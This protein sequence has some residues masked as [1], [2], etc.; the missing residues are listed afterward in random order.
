MLLM[1]SAPRQI[2]RALSI[3]E[4]QHHEYDTVLQLI[5]HHVRHTRD[6]EKVPASDPK[7]TNLRPEICIFRVPSCIPSR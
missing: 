5:M 3:E 1:Y 7:Y 4:E 6:A 2:G